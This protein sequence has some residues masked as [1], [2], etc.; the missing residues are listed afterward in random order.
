[1]FTTAQTFILYNLLALGCPLLCFLSE[2]KQSKW[3]IY[4]AYGIL[5]F[6]TVFRY[7]IGDD[8]VRYASM[9][10]HAA[11]RDF[12]T[13]TVLDFLS[14]E[15]LVYVFSFLFQWSDYPFAWCMGVY[16]ILTLF[17]YYKAFEYYK[18]HTIGTFLLC[19]TYVLFQAWDGVRQNLSIA[20]FFYCTRYIQERRFIPFLI[21]VVVGMLSHY[22][23][24]MVLPF[25]FLN[26]IKLLPV[27]V[28]LIVFG[29]FALAEVGILANA[30]TKLVEHVPYYGQIYANTKYMQNGEGSYHSSTYIL[31]MLFYMAV[32]YMSKREHS[33]YAN[34]LA[35]GAII[36]AIAGGN[37]NIMRI[38]WYFTPA[39][40]ILIPKILND[41]GSINE[42][43]KTFVR[44]IFLFL[45]LMALFEGVYLYANF[46]N[47]IPYETIFADE[48]QHHVFRPRESGV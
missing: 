3:G 10:N 1:M 32:L 5:L 2:R 12:A 46:R 47:V 15:P 36:Y 14:E 24:F 23:M 6:F 22:S 26:R 44:Y 9:F 48:F 28:T 33:L 18:C 8:Y 41:A 38:S 43:N 16:A 29:V 35:V 19:V 40:M 17:L 25:Y 34:I 11:A 20:V 13:L 7:D 4:I 30:L 21:G 37:F 27:Y 39:L 42:Y 31:T 45:V